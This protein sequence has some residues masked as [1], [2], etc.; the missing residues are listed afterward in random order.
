MARKPRQTPK[1]I[2]EIYDAGENRL[3]QERNDFLL[4]QVQGFVREQRWLNLR[5]EYQRRLVWDPG[6]KSRFMESL[7]MNIPIPP[8]FLFE[9]DLNRY[10]VMDGQQRLN[11][12]L[13]FYENRLRLKGLQVWSALNGLTYD[14]CPPRIKRGFD[15]RRISATVLL[16][17]NAKSVEDEQRIRRQVFERLNTGGQQLNAQELRNALYPGPLND[18]LKELAATRSFNEAWDIPPYKEHYLENGES[19]SEELANNRHFRRMLDCELIL[20][21]AA[22][23][24]TSSIK[25]AVKTI[26]D[27]YMR[28]HQDAN[29]SVID[30]V[31]NSFLESLE[32]ACRIF[33]D[34]VFR[35]EGESG[36]CRVST[37]LYDAV[38]VATNGLRDRHE[39]LINSRR[40]IQEA[41]LCALNDEEKYE[42]IVGRPNTAGAIKG[43]IALVRE[44][45]SGCI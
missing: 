3:T 15:R 14:D 34:G 27:N 40:A 8:I 13:E 26:L 39:D 22:F 1:Q 30:E 28:D 7:L 31:R 24:R 23:K 6:K 10:E 21:F 29:G 2:E 35:I 20:R 44:L 11:T 42:V 38:M 5:P 17:E 32:L 12:I 4:P 45:M 37:P 19:I 9:Y 25:G 43:R 41:L 16:A 33:G 36:K 18:L